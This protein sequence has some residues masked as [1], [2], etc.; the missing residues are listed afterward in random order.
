M[1]VVAAFCSSLQIA[2]LHHAHSKKK[3]QQAKG[4]SIYLKLKIN[5]AISIYLSFFLKSLLVCQYF[6]AQPF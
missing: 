4:F 3:P 2:V 1:D 5:D 6:S